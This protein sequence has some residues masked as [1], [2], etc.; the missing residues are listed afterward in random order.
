MERDKDRL[1]KI[2]AQIMSTKEA[3]RLWNKGEET[4]KRNIRSGK[5]IAERLDENSHH[6]AYIILRDQPNPFEDKK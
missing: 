1:K 3:A 6:S 2:K 5:I 4:I